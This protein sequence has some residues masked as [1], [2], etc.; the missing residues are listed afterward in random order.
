[1]S[2]PTDSSRPVV[3]VTSY[4][5]QADWANWP[6]EAVLVPTNYLDRLAASGVSPVLLPPVPD[7]DDALLEASMER[8]DGLVLIGGEDVCGRAYGRDETDDDHDAARHRPERDRHEIA[9][10]RVAWEQQKPILAICR[11]IQLLNVAL[12]GTL[13][14]D[15]ATSG[16]MPEHRLQW[17]TFHD[18]AVDFD[19]GS[20]LAKIYG[21]TAQVPSHHHQAIDTL[22]DGLVVTGRAPDG[23]VEGVEATN[24]NY[25]LGVQWHPEE[26]AD[27]E[28]FRAFAAACGAPA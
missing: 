16:A 5:D 27:V 6:Q 3:G 21:D 13:I 14:T 1:M 17:G 12:G 24:G 11:G 19:P 22:A 26:G 2:G 23:I 20:V 15:L 4:R 10:A 8:V 28:I 7:D 9:A 18:H 25:V